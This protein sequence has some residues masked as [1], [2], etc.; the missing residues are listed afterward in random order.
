[1]ST[2]TPTTD[3]A[4]SQ[5][6]T[7]SAPPVNTESASATST[8]SSAAAVT[9]TATSTVTSAAASST[10]GAVFKQSHYERQP[11]KPEM[12]FDAFEQ[13]KSIL[14]GLMKQLRPGMDLSKVVLPTHILEPRSFLDKTTDYFVH[15]ELINLAA[16]QTDPRSRLIYILRWYLSGFYVT[17]QMLKKPYNPVLGETYRCSWDFPEDNSNAFLVCEQVSHHPP[18]SAFYVSNRAHGWVVNGAVAFKSKF[19]GTSAGT[20]QE[21]YGSLHLLEWDEEY[22]FTF[23]SACAK[24]FIIGPLTVEFYGKMSIECEKTG[25]K[26]EFEFLLKP[27]WYGEY[28]HVSGSIKY[29]DEVLYTLSG[30]W[31]KEMSLKDASTGEIQTLWKVTPDLAE[32]RKTRLLIPMEEQIP[33]ES[34]KLWIGVTNAL[35]AG[36]QETAT[37]EKTKIEEAQRALVRERDKNGVTWV[38]RYFTWD[39]TREQWFY[40]WLNTSPMSDEDKFEYEYEFKIGRRG[41]PT[42]PA[43]STTTPTSTSESTPAS[44]PTSTPAPT[45]TTT[46]TT[47]SGQNSS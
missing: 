37:A 35:I 18:I 44:T 20:V 7:T 34:E 16:K 24:G 38:P 29:Y 6:S 41:S 43:A 15:I 33:T 39:A 19:W 27:L 21:G 11:P 17:P 4:A 28:N 12:K 23:P 3:G 47:S 14:F 32:Q 46:T 9:S 22:R 26:A 5:P 1:M 2:E 31:D 8:A 10:P 13:G 40:N 30:R 45:T 42:T 36:D 25:Y